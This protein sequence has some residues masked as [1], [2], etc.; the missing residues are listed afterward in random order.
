MDGVSLFLTPKVA[1]I[2]TALSAGK[3][4]ID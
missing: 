3:K 1:N 4:A 2:D